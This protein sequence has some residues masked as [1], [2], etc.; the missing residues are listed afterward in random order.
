MSGKN[1]LSFNDQKIAKLPIPDKGRID[2]RDEK[3]PKLTCRVASSGS[4]IFA[5]NVWDNGSSKRV[6]IGQYPA[7]TVTLARKLTLDILARLA[8]GEDIN[9][10]KRIKRTKSSLSTL[11]QVIEKYLET[12]KLKPSTVKDYRYKIS[13]DLF[14]L[15]QKSIDDIT[16]QDVIQVQKRLT[17]T[18]TSLS[19]AALRVL[20]LTL[21]YAVAIKLIESSPASVITTARLMAKPI[22]KA[23]I[24]PADKLGEWLSAVNSLNNYKARVYLLLLLFTGL[25]SSE[26]LGLKWGDIDL[27]KNTLKINDTKNSSTHT[28]PIPIYLLTFLTVLE[29]QKINQWVFGT[30]NKGGEDASMSI[31]RKPILVVVKASGIEFSPHDLRRTFATIS[32]AVELPASMSK[33]LLNHGATHNSDVTSGYIISEEKTIRQAINKISDF[34]IKHSN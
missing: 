2:Y 6:T 9:E 4:K 8:R 11:L 3:N 24:I 1:V 7:I 25:R 5:V 34:I 20:K 31:P 13:H 23:R 12:H 17:K 26:A 29:Q 10:Q 19:N 22:R 27:A 15:A 32:E 30:K 14:D 21:N 33:R 18:S 28:L 16:E